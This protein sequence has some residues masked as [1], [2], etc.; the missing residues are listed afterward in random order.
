[1]N[2]PR[3]NPLRLGL[4]LAGALA[5]ACLN[6]AQAQLAKY[7]AETVGSDSFVR[8]DGTS[9][10][11]DWRVASRLVG[12]SIE[13]DPAFL[14]KPA[15]GKVNA[16]A[17]AI[18]PVRQ[19]KSYEDD[20]LEK[21]YSTAMD[22]VMYDAMKEAQFR[23]IEYRLT[24]MTLKE[25]PKAATDPIVVDTV[26]ELIIAGVTNK[27]TMPVTIERPAAGKLKFSGKTDVKMT[28]FGIKPPAPK[29]AL[30]AIKTGDDVK[31]SF[32]WLTKK[33]E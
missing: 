27:V 25:A 21:F 13:I 4:G 16:T 19:L 9:T 6:T 26:G 18:I 3:L 7:Q 12:G 32:N 1:M 14:D 17:R 5:L 8:I 30:G 33:A 31:L 15:A 22:N 23:R 11:H 24:E 10:L 20:K 29:I 2:K 28:S